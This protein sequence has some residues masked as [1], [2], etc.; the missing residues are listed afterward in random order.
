MPRKIAED[1]PQFRQVINNAR[2]REAL[3][4]SLTSGQLFGQRPNRWRKP[5]YEKVDWIKEGF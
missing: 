1:H 4:R 3:R 5:P 2:R